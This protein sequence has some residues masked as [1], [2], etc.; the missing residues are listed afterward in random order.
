VNFHFNASSLRDEELELLRVDR[1]SELQRCIT[2]LTEHRANVLIFGERGVGKTFLAKVLR[3]RLVADCPDVFTFSA[4]VANLL[5]Y[6]DEP[7]AGFSALVL[8]ELCLA[9]WRQD[10]GK[11]YSALRSAIDES[12]PP[13]MSAPPAEDAIARVMR[14]LLTERS[15]SYEFASIVG[16]AIGA[17]AEKAEKTTRQAKLSRV[18]PFEFV[19]L[20]EEVIA[21]ALAPKGKSEII[22]I[23]DEA[24][25][26]PIYYQQAILDASLEMFGSKRIRFAF[27]AGH[28]HWESIPAVPIC[29]DTTV[30]LRGLRSSPAKRLIRKAAEAW[31]VE[32]SGDAQAI[33]IRASRG[34][35]RYMLSVL[36]SAVEAVQRRNPSVPRTVLLRDVNAAIRRAEAA[37]RHSARSRQ[38][39][40]DRTA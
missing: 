13:L 20:T 7:V 11:N 38:R 37:L 8:L 9:I 16:L 36:G 18:L 1:E 14:I 30:H 2:A 25:L 22:V 28:L 35:P 4:N 15:T 33:L 12:A 29:F 17:K 40:S 32:V 27:V 5:G 6:A 23:C 3:Q 19:E 24:N 39:S 21:S 34:N 10:I 31:R 26:L